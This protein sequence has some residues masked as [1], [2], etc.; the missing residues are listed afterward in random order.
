MGLDNGIVYKGERR[1]NLGWLARRVLPF[2]RIDEEDELTICYW[3][4][5][6]NVRDAI[7]SNLNSVR[8]GERTILQISDLY[9]IRR[10]ILNFLLHPKDWHNSI[11]TY[12][13]IR[14]HL[15]RQIVA[16]SLLIKWMKHDASCF[17]YFYDSF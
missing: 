7:M 2:Y 13:E 14:P 12:K 10:L 1:S 17:V 5:C 11:W 16:L 3:R 8:V 15:M 4:K 6:W 9:V